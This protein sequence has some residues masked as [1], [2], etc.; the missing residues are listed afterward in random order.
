MYMETLYSNV[1][2]FNTLN[3]KDKIKTLQFLIKN[4]NR[5]VKIIERFNFNIL[6]LSFTCTVQDL[7]SNLNNIEL[8]SISQNNLTK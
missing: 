4:K 8:Q 7:I 1:E 3:E 6:S 5:Y 2:H